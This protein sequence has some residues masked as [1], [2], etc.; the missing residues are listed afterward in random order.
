[1]SRKTVLKQAAKY[2]K[3]A[4][5]LHQ[6]LQEEEEREHS[7]IPEVRHVDNM[8]ALYSMDAAT[9]TDYERPVHVDSKS[10]QVIPDN[11]LFDAAESA[12]LDREL[13]EKE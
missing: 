9:P 8:A 4:P 1:M 11:P 12:A 6:L 10:G 13:A 2:V 7:D 3:G 5:R